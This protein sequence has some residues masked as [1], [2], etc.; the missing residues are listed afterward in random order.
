MTDGFSGERLR[1]ARLLNCMS[2]ADLAATVGVTRQ[3]VHALEIGDKKPTRELLLAL[4]LPL[5][6]T[7]AFFSQPRVAEIKEEQ[8]HFR[9]R[10]TTPLVHRQQFIAHGTLF[11]ALIKHL[12]KSLSLPKV[13]IPHVDVSNASDV[14]E[15]LEGA[16][17]RGH[18]LRHF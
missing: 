13:D 3:Y 14:D 5:N 18:G 7:A 16:G 10:K 12:E 8:C 1:L 2:Q 17:V 15:A 9:S 6:V 11:N 4:C